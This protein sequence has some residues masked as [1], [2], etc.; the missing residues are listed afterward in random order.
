MSN[1]SPMGLTRDSLILYLPL[2]GAAFAYLAVMPPPTQWTY[3]QWIQT[4]AA[5]IAAITAWLKTSPLIGKG[6]K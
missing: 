2:L 5:S 3:A 4:G 1:L 6:D